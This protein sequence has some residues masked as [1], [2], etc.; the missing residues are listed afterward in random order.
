V[1]G[2]R[3]LPRSHR[4][5][6]GGFEGFL[7][8]VDAD[9]GRVVRRLPGHS[10]AVFTPGISA[11]GRLMVTGSNESVRF[12]S[13]PDGRPLGAPLRFPLPPVEAQLSPDGR[14]AVVVT[15]FSDRL[16]IIDARTREVRTAKGGELLYYARFSPDGRTIAVGDLHGR[17]EVWS[18]ATWRPITRPFAGHAGGAMLGAISPDN[19][20]LVTG[21]SDGTLRLWDIKSQQ[22]LGAP[23]PGLP[24]HPVIPLF[25]PDGTALIAA[26]DIGRA[27]RWDIRTASLIRQACRVAGR[28]LTRAEW[29]EF[30]P[31]RDYKPAC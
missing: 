27:Y 16:Q 18:T 26:Y 25:T 19:R 17:T 1:M 5:V 12:W 31:D 4:L 15:A 29:Q 11:D 13:L 23:L 2:M 21:S 8:I 30:L 9:S 14:W 22:P 7:A 20:T 10:R 6:V 3:F 24:E 28:R